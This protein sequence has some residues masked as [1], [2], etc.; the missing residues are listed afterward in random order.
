MSLL[1]KN[2]IHMAGASHTAPAA[3]FL[4]PC[5]VCGGEGAIGGIWEGDQDW[6]EPCYACQGSGGIVA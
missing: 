3:L 6:W 1:P 2:S 4:I 5:P